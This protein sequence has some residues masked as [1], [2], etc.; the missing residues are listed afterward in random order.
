[1]KRKWF[2]TALSVMV[3][4]AMC[5]A[6]AACQPEESEVTIS[7]ENA[8]ATVE[9]DQTITLTVSVS[10]TEDEVVWSS[11]DEDVATV[12]ASATDSTKATVT[13]V[14]EGSAAITAAVGGKSAVCTVTVTAAEAEPEPV[15]VSVSVAP[16]TLSLEAGKTGSVTATVTGTDDEVVWSSADEDVATVAA[17]ATDSTKATVTAVA[18]GGP[19]NITAT[20]GDKSDSCAVTVTAPAPVV[21]EYEITE[22]FTY[23]RYTAVQEGVRVA[24]T[25]DFTIDLSA[26]EDFTVAADT[27]VTFSLYDGYDT[28]AVDGSVSADNVFA[29]ACADV[30]DANLYEGEYTL[31]IATDD[32]EIA[33]PVVIAT[34]V[35]ETVA[36]LNSIQAYAGADGVKLNYGGYFELGGNIDAEGAVVSSSGAPYYTAASGEAGFTV[37]G[38]VATNGFTGT[39]DGK[40]YVISNAVF[41]NGGLLGYVSSVG[42]VKNLAIVNATLGGGESGGGVISGNF[43][44]EADNLLV[45]VSTFAN[46]GV[47]MRGIFGFTLGGARISNS[48]FYWATEFDGYM[49]APLGGDLGGAAA[50]NTITNTYCFAAAETPD[51]SAGGFQ[52]FGYYSA[53]FY[54]GL[55]EDAVLARYGEIE[56][57]GPDDTLT[58]AGVDANN[59]DGDIWDLSG[60]VARFLK[61]DAVA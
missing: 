59:F 33:V 17:S 20:V 15:E 46:T 24:N 37:D 28:F 50:N 21:E 31:T 11:A 22:T 48:I 42:K 57:C 54:A 26:E 41:E 10:G 7:F 43:Y 30:T 38:K 8:S 52:S 23:E 18:A 47:T 40:G 19:V 44:G 3:A 16:G 55:T 13:G 49:S 12:E 53:F 2:L 39:F 51:V 4:A 29:L 5:F 14:S 27:A 9:E 58:A 45:D 35:L 32:T 56:L 25:A 34:A 61:Q 60:D 6:F 1:M 36:D